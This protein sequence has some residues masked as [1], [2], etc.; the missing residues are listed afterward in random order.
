MKF[1]INRLENDEITLGQ[2]YIPAYV[3][4]NIGYSKFRNPD[5][6]A[7]QEILGKLGSQLT[8][9]ILRKFL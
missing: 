1:H 3:I 9:A 5:F 4:T 7:S 6:P 2:L 8:Q